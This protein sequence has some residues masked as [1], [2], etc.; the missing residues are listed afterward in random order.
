MMVMESKIG[1]GKLRGIG[2]SY[3]DQIG[4]SVKTFSPKSKMRKA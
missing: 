1:N 3:V 4:G 2:G